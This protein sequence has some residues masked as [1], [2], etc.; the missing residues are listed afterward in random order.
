MADD[1]DDYGS[2]T[3]ETDNAPSDYDDGDGSD[4]EDFPEDDSPTDDDS[5]EDAAAETD[6]PESDLDVTS[7]ASDDESDEIEDIEEPEN[8]DISDDQSSTEDEIPDI[9]EST[10]SEESDLEDADMDPP[11]EI[12][13]EDLTDTAVDA[14]TESQDNSADYIPEEDTGKDSLI[15]RLIHKESN[16]MR[17]EGLRQSRENYDSYMDYEDENGIKRSERDP[18]AQNKAQ[19]YKEY[20]DSRT[21]YEADVKRYE[22]G[23][24]AARTVAGAAY[25]VGEKLA[26]K[27]TG[28]QLDPV[29]SKQLKDTAK[30]MGELYYMSKHE[31]PVDKSGDIRPEGL[32]QYDPDEMARKLF[33]KDSM[34]RMMDRNQESIDRILDG[35]E[36]SIRKTAEKKWEDV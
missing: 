27:L 6:I 14:N 32:P 33:N 8:D 10:L 28:A 29:N 35:N 13:P 30:N 3:Y 19:F 24:D 15:G 9:P 31:Y 26:S 12:P 11:D 23:A 22:E 21:N 1:T 36:E 16:R 2:D 20:D 5:I 7:T 18:Y 34:D 25:K 17:E 4:L